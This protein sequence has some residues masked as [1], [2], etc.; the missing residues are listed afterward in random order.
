MDPLTMYV[1]LWAGSAF[2]SWLG[3]KK[4]GTAAKAAGESAAQQQEFN[5]AVAE[6][7]AKDAIGRGND[8]QSDFRS[9]VRGL[10]GS[11][12]AAFAGGNVDVTVGSAVDVTADSAFLGEL[13]V[14]K[15]RRNAER[16]AWGYQVEAA[17]RRMAADVARKGGQAQ[18]SAYTWNSISSIVGSGAQA[19]QSLILAKYGWPKPKAA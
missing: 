18:A 8:A 6:L 7:Q 14:Q 4:A 13:D 1:A 11:Q 17:D 12:R 2:I 3:G 19:G 16:E 5:A 15:I 10:I 9:Q